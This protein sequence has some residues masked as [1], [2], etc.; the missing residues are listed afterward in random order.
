MSRKEFTVVRTFD[1]PRD[2][3][4]KAHTEAERMRHWWGPKGFTMLKFTL[5]LKPGGLCHYGMRGPTGM[6]MWGKLV[7]REIAKPTRLSYVVSFSDAQ[8]GTTRHPL[9]TTWPLEV[10]SVLDFTEH[11]GKTTLTITGHPI[12]ASEIE[13]K[14]YDD[15]HEGMNAGF[16]GTMDQL[17]A[18]LAS[19]K[20]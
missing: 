18:Y 19:A 8:G 6:E 9:A 10:L 11:A 7:F 17:E 13:I 14:T 2:L 4:W 5:D 12:N 15:A 20:D 1:A 3:V 16:K